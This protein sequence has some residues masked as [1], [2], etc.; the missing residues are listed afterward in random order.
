[1]REEEKSKRS[2]RRLD[3][4]MQDILKPILCICHR[5]IRPMHLP[6]PN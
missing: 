5:P 1:M 4:V 2:R 6:Q 3:G